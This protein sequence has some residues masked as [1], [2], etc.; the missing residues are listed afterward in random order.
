MYKIVMID[1][2]E[3]L[4]IA[5]KRMLK[6]IEKFELATLSD[7]QQAEEFIRA[8]KPHVILLDSVMPV[9]SG[10][11]IIAVL[12]DDEELK[13]IPIIVVSGRG[14]MV[15]NKRKENF[16]WQSNTK[17]VKERGDLPDARGAKA[18]A[19]A[20]GVVDYIAKPFSA[21]QFT[22]VVEEVLAKFYKTP[23]Q[24]DA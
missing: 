18:L 2:E 4:C 8:E 24:E 13:H 5:V 22:L 1:D 19:E 3:N 10:S 17:V 9:R 16:Q 6:S 7:P 12:R 23:E 20:Y 14:E 21:E 11:D 15:Y